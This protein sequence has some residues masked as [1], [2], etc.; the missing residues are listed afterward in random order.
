MHHFICSVVSI[1]TPTVLQVFPHHAEFRYREVELQRSIKEMVKRSLP[2]LTKFEPRTLCL[3]CYSK[4]KVWYRAIIRSYNPS[5]KTVDV[6]YVDYLNSET[7]PLKY[8]RQCPKELLGWPLRTFRVR[9]HGIQVNPNVKEHDIRM[10]LQRVLSKRKLFAVV[11]KH[12]NY[13][14]VI[15]DNNTNNNTDL[16]EIALYESKDTSLKG[17]TIYESLIEK[18][19][20]QRY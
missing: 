15:L 12:P 17:V 19:Y 18:N 3:A 13:N 11:K 2:P 1:I 5:A 4:D 10:S 16:I 6:L 8:I 7:L 14:S 9:L 20:F